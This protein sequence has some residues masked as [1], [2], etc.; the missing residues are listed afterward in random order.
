MCLQRPSRLCLDPDPMQRHMP[1]PRAL[2]RWHWCGMH[3]CQPHVL[4]P[5]AA[6]DSY[7]SVDEGTPVSTA[8]GAP[9]INTDS[10]QD[11]VSAC[12][13]AG[14]LDRTQAV[15]QPP[16]GLCSARPQ[17]PAAP[18]PPA[19]PARRCRPAPASPGTLC[20]AAATSRPARAGGSSGAGSAGPPTST[21]ARSSRGPSQ[22]T[23]APGQGMPVLFFFKCPGT[24]PTWAGG[25][26]GPRVGPDA[27]T[28]RRTHTKHQ[29]PNQ[30]TSPGC[31]R[32]RRGSPVDRG[33]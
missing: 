2:P 8:S 3:T 28:P 31:N 10:V 5:A 19:S 27:T 15:P 23:A 22:W 4:P 14:V 7:V 25:R 16:A 9:Y 13:K 20:R 26:D 11:C 29:I 12:D 33:G 24:R 6:P 32:K 17:P 1:T 21:W 30:P 18:Y